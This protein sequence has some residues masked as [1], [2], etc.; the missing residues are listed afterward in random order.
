M[1]LS[2]KL[3]KKCIIKKNEAFREIFQRGK[4]WR[5]KLIKVFFTKS[6]KY[7]VGFSV[8]R[9][10]GNAVKRNRAKRLLRE[11]YRRHLFE[12]PTG[13]MVLVPKNDWG[14]IRYKDVEK[15]M[16]FFIEWIKQQNDY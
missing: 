2:Q 13:H 5:G 15:E 7:A 8:P 11:A 4:I 16:V 3:P 10:F 12:L 14:S 6:D 9:K 1:K